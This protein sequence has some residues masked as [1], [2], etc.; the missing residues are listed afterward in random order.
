MEETGWRA[1]VIT[2]HSG[3]NIWWQKT[4]PTSQIR[5]TIYPTPKLVR[6]PDYLTQ[7]LQIQHIPD[8]QITHK[9]QLP[10]AQT[11]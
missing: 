11:N 7:I 5:I 6:I 1:P 9:D 8:A 3:V 10:D 4:V 2:Q